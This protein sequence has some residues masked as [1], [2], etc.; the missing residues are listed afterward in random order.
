MYKVKKTNGIIKNAFRVGSII[1]CI[2]LISYNLPNSQ[3]LVFADNGD[4]KIDLNNDGKEEIVKFNGGEL[5]IYN[6]D[7]KLIFQKDEDKSVYSNMSFIKDKKIDDTKVLIQN[8]TKDTSGTLSYYIYKMDDGEMVEVVHKE[9]IYKGIIT[10]KDNEEILE[11]IPIYVENDSNAVPSDTVKNYF[12]LEDNKLVLIKTEKLKYTPS[13]DASISEYYNNPSYAETEKMLESIANE[14]GIPTVIFKAIAYQESTWRQFKDG[15]P[16]IGS[17]HVGIGIMQVS[18]YGSTDTTYINRLKYDI[19]FNIREGADILLKK[20]ALQTYD[21]ATYK[22]PR[23]GNASPNYLEH[24]Y[25]AIWAYNGYSVRN[26]P[27]ANTVDPKGYPN[28]TYQKLVIGHA[29]NVFK[30]PMLDLYVYNPNLFPVVQLPINL[31]VNLPRTDIAEISG[32]HAGNLKVKEKNYKYMTTTNLTIRD[33]NMVATSIYYIENDIVTIK[34]EPIIKDGY[35]NYYVEGSTKSGYV[36]GNWLKPVGD[37][38]G[39]GQVDIYDFVKQSKNINGQGTVVNDTNR[40]SIGNSDVNVD[41][42]IDIK[43]IALTALNYNFSLYR[44]DIKN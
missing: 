6:S 38:N 39:D 43:D 28:A 29:N 20:W 23:V 36:R 25:Y 32:K 42:I 14:K 10:V 33:A 15:Q 22:I 34:G 8:K 41:G 5:K 18:D 30:N 35:V 3:K 27:R 1:V 16:L 44:S 17:D 12:T 26:N 21:G 4:T 31:A 9:N 2:I 40:I 13:K 19:E 24:W 11:E 37:T 7:G